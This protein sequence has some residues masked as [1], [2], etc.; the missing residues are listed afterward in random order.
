MVQVGEPRNMTIPTLRGPGEL[1]ATVPWMLG[2]TPH[3]SVIVIGVGARGEVGVI[4]RVDREDCLIPEVASSMTRSIAAQ[5][6]RE[7]AA[8]AILVSYTTQDVRMCCE[9]ADALRDALT[10]R[11]GRIDSWAVRDGKYFAPG[12]ADVT[13]C[14]IAGAPV[15]EL[16]GKQRGLRRLTPSNGP[17]HSPHSERWGGAPIQARR[18]SS[19]AAD[20]WRDKKAQ[21]EGPWRAS[22]FEMWRDQLDGTSGAPSAMADAHIGKMIAA[23]ADVRVRDAVIVSL[24][25]GS[26]RAVDD[27]LAGRSTAAVTAAL[28]SLITPWGGVSCDDHEAE[29]ACD[30]LRRG[31]ERCRRKEAAPLLAI[32]GLLEW[33]RAN[34]EGA[35][36]WC[37][38][39][40]ESVPGYRLAELVRATVLAGLEPGWRA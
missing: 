21:A 11:V 10:D 23:L 28:D 22:S 38:A 4:M 40:C 26:E 8:S 36:S 2:S 34:P 14:L 18:R 37:E 25:P 1:I 31:V 35:L 39:A 19:R 20:R 12:C 6:A 30:I 7:G 13:C 32:L 33:W 16:D 17:S 5:L 27:V 9:A 24:V 15:P 29:V 3:E